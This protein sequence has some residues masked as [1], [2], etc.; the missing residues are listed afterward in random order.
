MLYF[1]GLFDYFHKKNGERWNNGC[2]YTC[3]HNLFIGGLFTLQEKYD[4][5]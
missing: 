2:V 3:S 5:F 4:I 1:L